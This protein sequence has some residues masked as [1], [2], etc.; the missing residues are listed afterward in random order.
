V[1]P[2]AEFN[3]Y[4]DAFAAARVYALTSP[5]PR[6]TIPPGTSL[7]VYPASL[8][9]Q[10]TV[11]LFPLDITLRHNLTRGQFRSTITPLLEAGSPLATWVSA[12]MAHT[13]ATL[14]RL[15][16]KQ[17]G[18]SAEL[19]LHDP[20]CVWYAITAEDGGWKPSATSPEDIR[21]ETTGQ[22]TRG[23]CVV[24]RRDRHPIEGDEES[25][26]D[27]GLWLSARAGNRVWRMDQ[28]PVETTFGGILMDRIFS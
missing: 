14:E 15:H 13:F 21:V 3:S 6:S 12:F 18:D 2:V 7:P 4:A 24:D 9:K 11:R 19:S 23:L 22:W 25:S 8:G 16:P 1:T 17:N 5:S 27:H 26:S 20:V 10:L 28:S